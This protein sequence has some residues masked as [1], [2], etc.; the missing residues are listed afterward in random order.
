MSPAPA[1]R[2]LLIVAFVTTSRPLLAAPSA[3]PIA[4]IA[5]EV[6]IEEHLGQRVDPNLVFTDSSGRRVTLGEYLRDGKPAVVSL[7]YFRCPM[8]CGLVLRGLAH[9]LAEVP[10]RA[11][12][13][14][15][16]LTISF[17]PKDGA[18]EAARKQEAVLAA[19]GKKTERA[20][21]PFLV[22]GAAEIRAIAETF[23]FRFAYDETIDQYAHPAAVFILPPDGRI[24]R[25]LY[26]TVF[27]PRDLRLSLVEAG[28]GKVGSIVDRV[29]LPC[30]RFDPATRRFGPFIRGFMRIG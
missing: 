24:S 8:L 28:S 9:G 25:Y 20:A 13:D 29:L 12:E 6:D 16:L 3:P 2:C 10:F 21:W 14:Y 11:G 27:S 26:G 30:Y 7:A 17:D 5:R 15:R 22:G 1:L 18:A 23:G 19:F 4:P